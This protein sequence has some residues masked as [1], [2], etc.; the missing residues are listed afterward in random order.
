MKKLQKIQLIAW[1]IITAICTV[2]M[3]IVPSHKLIMASTMLF[4][5]MI[6]PVRI[7]IYKL[8]IWAIDTLATHD[9]DIYDRIHPLATYVHVQNESNRDNREENPV[10][11]RTINFLISIIMLIIGICCLCFQQISFNCVYIILYTVEMLLTFKIP[12]INILLYLIVTIC[13]YVCLIWAFR[14]TVLDK[15]EVVLNGNY[16]INWKEAWWRF[17]IPIIATFLKVILTGLFFRFTSIM[18]INSVLYSIIII[19]IIALLYSCFIGI[20]QRI[21]Q[22]KE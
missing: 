8:T 3:F 11:F 18:I 13:Y 1:A 10:F 7:C 22:S 16:S 5:T 12:A 21:N 17:T 20:L 9:S 15:H 14:E 4:V 2:V 19:L 6:F